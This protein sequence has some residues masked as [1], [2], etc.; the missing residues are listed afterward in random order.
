MSSFMSPHTPQSKRIT[1]SRRPVIGE[2]SGV[3]TPHGAAS[4]H[5]W[6]L[7]ACAGASSG[8]C[9]Q[10]ALQSLKC[11]SRC[12][13]IYHNSP[14]WRYELLELISVRLMC[15]GVLARRSFCTA[16]CV[17]SAP[18]VHRET[19]SFFPELFRNRHIGGVP[20]LKN[21][22]KFSCVK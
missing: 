2:L 12:S 10:E 1:D 21:M 15:V 8:R 7:G 19:A 6:Q 3:L 22:L 5:I 14:V 17:G 16:N 20:P 4:D 11:S 9:K 13:R 18:F